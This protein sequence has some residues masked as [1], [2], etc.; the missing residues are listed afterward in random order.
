MQGRRPTPPPGGW[1]PGEEPKRGY[2]F[3]KEKF[4]AS[5]ADEV[6]PREFDTTSPAAK[7]LQRTSVGPVTFP[8]SRRGRRV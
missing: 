7:Y 5:H 1:R 4:G 6:A 8:P 3:L 2:R